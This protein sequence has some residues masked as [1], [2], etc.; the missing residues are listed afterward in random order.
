MQASSSGLQT[1]LL[2]YSWFGPRAKGPQEPNRAVVVGRQHQ[3]HLHTM[4]WNLVLSAHMST[5]MRTKMARE[6]RR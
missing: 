2:D 5:D 1:I 4:R 6:I 3:R